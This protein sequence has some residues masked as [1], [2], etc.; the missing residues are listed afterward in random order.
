[1]Q[2]WRTL[3][4]DVII[5]VHT[6]IEIFFK[7]YRIASLHLLITSKQKLRNYEI[8]TNANYMYYENIK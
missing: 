4:H 8:K 6:V 3:I 7:K 5:G 1:M 2:F